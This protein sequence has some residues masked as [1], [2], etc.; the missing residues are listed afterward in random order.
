MGHSAA[1]DAIRRVNM[2][3]HPLPTRNIPVAKP[4]GGA[5][6][7]LVSIPFPSKT[8]I[9]QTKNLPRR[10]H[11]HN[12]GATPG[13]SSTAIHLRPFGIVAYVIGFDTLGVSKEEQRR[14]RLEVEQTWITACMRY[15][16]VPTAKERL[17]AWGWVQQQ[18][19]R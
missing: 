11:E 2:Q 17:A 14:A 8:Y 12:R 13:A 19:S 10:L 9:G 1:R 3:Y 16:T 6:Y 5:V 15:N 7:L 18:S 4:I